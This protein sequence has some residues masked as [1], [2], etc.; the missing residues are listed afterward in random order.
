[1][2]RRVQLVRR[3]GRLRRLWLAPLAVAAAACPG[4]VGGAPGDAATD[5]EVDA[6]H[7]VTRV[8]ITEI[9]AEPR[10]TEPRQRFDAAN[11]GPYVEEGDDDSLQYVELYN[12][13]A[14]AVELTGWSL[15]EGVTYGF[16]P[17]TRLEPA[18]YLVV[19]AD[20]ARLA[21]LAGVRG[22]LG[23][24]T[25]RLRH[26]G[27]TI[28]LRDDVG[29]AADRVTYGALPP[30]SMR[31]ATA[32][33]SLERISIASER[34][35]ADN[36]RASTAAL[37]APL[38]GAGTPGAA[39][40]VAADVIPPLV[41][42][43]AHAPEAPA[44]G[45][46]V[47]ITARVTADAPLTSV[48]LLT[49]TGLDPA[50]T[51]TPMADDGA[52]G[53]GA[54]GDGVYG[55]IVPGAAARTLVHYRVRA[56]AATGTTEYPYADDPAPTRAYY[57]AAPPGSARYHLFLPQ[58]SIDA[59]A[60]AARAA[61]RL[62]L[63]VDGTLVIDGVAYPHVRVSLGG[64]WARASTPYAWHFKLQPDHPYRDVTS[65]H[66]TWN[67]PDV[68]QPIF[69]AF[70]AVGLPHL[71]A[72]VVD[73]DLTSGTVDGPWGHYVVYEAPGKGWLTKHAYPAGTALY[74]ARSCESSGPRRNS[75]LYYFGDPGD[76]RADNGLQTDLDYQ[77]AY[78]NEVD[79]FA[80]PD[81][82]RALV[83][84]LGE[85]P[86]ADLLAWLDANVDVDTWFRSIA[87]HVYLR[88][89]DFSTHN[90][91]LLRPAGGK[92]QVLNYDFDQFANFYVQPALYAAGLDP[93]ES[94]SWQRNRL[95]QRIAGSPTLRRVYFLDLRAL[96]AA[97]PPSAL[98]PPT[99]QAPVE[100]ARDSLLGEL[101]AANLP[102]ATAAPA[103]APCGGHA[104]PA[105]SVHLTVPAGWDAYYTLDGSDPRLS[106][107]RI[108]YASPIAVPAAATLRAAALATGTAPAAGNWTDRTDCAFGP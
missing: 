102:P 55:A 83:A 9:M 93:R 42:E 52:H 1:M 25:G 26:G 12:P 86:D 60:A 84:A 82:V 17:G 29:A 13:N 91:Y 76:E 32:G 36:W 100:Q 108:P 35:T 30:W 89:T 14:V 69:A 24:F 75:D 51:T 10:R 104:G 99:M 18:A 58:P 98:V 22:A 27:E 5:A 3:A 62:D 28:S 44:A 79:A 7:V 105:T 70:A 15:A 61:P 40:S 96:L 16:P 19:A 85:L 41:A 43:L 21:A 101:D 90:Y 39:N 77:G 67:R 73:L 45:Q 37:P 48:E 71:D 54:A 38:A 31:A 2:T 92:W 74:K 8:V 46:A 59:L 50:V 81:D 49:S 97:Y 87:L 63:D 6:P 94:P 47:T 20:P 88:L 11:G 23:P 53:D 106:P 33:A 95:H 68:Q 65:L 103:A 66:L 78:G 4:H 34:T 57:H 80:P 72:E 64:R 56:T 107:T